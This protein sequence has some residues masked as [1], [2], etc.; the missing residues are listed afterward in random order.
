MWAAWIAAGDPFTRSRCRD[1]AI[2]TDYLS[3][4]RDFSPSPTPAQNKSAERDHPHQQRNDCREL[5]RPSM[6][7]HPVIS[8]RIFRTTVSYKAGDT[9]SNTGILPVK[10]VSGK[11]RRRVG[12]WARRTADVARAEPYVSE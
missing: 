11:Q 3:S 9:K 5:P 1:S 2:R 10:Q 8:L 7:C 12:I 4:C 6:S